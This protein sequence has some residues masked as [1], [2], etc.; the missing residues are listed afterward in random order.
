MRIVL[1]EKL[2]PK[3]IGIVQGTGFMPKC[4]PW[5]QHEKESIHERAWEI[6]SLG[7]RVTLWEIVT[8]GDTAA[9]NQTPQFEPS[10]MSEVTA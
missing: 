2:D 6:Y 3:I 7:V 4:C 5:W 10:V 8:H 1:D 9:K